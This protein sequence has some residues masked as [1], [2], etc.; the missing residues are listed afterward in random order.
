MPKWNGSMG[1][2]Y[3]FTMPVFAPRMK[4][5]PLPTLVFTK[6]Q[7]SILLRDIFKSSIKKLNPQTVVDRCRSFI[8]KSIK[9]RTLRP[10]GEI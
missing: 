7:S 3:Y 1:N 6:I 8:V 9:N 10:S 2:T 4:E 5:S